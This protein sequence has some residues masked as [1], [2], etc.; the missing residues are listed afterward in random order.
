[1]AIGSQNLNARYG[2]TRRS[3]ASGLFEYRYQSQGINVVLV[4]CLL[5][6]LDVYLKAHSI[7]LGIFALL[8]LLFAFAVPYLRQLLALTLSS[9]YVVMAIAFAREI[10]TGYH[11]I[12]TS[13]DQVG[14]GLVV[15]LIA[16][17]L[18]TDF[19]TWVRDSA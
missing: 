1:M 19:L 17:S 3:V 8:G 2:L 10:A 16:Y 4:E 15:F 13:V 14:I 5:L 11:H 9:L 6:S 18:H 7:G 12:L